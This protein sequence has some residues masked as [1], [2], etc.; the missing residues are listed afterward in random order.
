MRKRSKQKCALPVKK[1][2]LLLSNMCFKSIF[3]LLQLHWP[4]TGVSI[5][6]TNTA[7]RKIIFHP[8]KHNETKKASIL[9]YLKKT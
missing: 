1:I 9:I 2:S 8:T 6:K 7:P 3:S 4:I 5:S